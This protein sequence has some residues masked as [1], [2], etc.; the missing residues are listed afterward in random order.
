MRGCTLR[1]R[2]RHYRKSLPAGVRRIRLSELRGAAWH[3]T[4]TDSR[5]VQ[6]WWQTEIKRRHRLIFQNH[7]QW[8]LCAIRFSDEDIGGLRERVTEREASRRWHRYV[9]APCSRR[10]RALM[11]PPYTSNRPI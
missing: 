4:R 10:Y 5:T 1:Q 2:M 6:F 7:R 11:H 3:S 8:H 9:F